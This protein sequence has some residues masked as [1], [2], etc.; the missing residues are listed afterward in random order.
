MRLLAFVF[1]ST[2]YKGS[3]ERDA[4]QCRLLMSLGRT[5]CRCVSRREPGLQDLG[6]ASSACDTL[7]HPRSFNWSG[8][9][10]LQIE[11]WSESVLSN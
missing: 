9:F 8:K 5:R 7:C 11:S 10:G 6:V 4:E 2:P 3:K 1:T